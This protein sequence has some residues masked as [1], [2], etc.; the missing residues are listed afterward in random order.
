MRSHESTF[1]RWNFWKKDF[2]SAAYQ[3]IE[4]T[5]SLMI[6]QSSTAAAGHTDIME[7]DRER[8]VYGVGLSWERAV[9]FTAQWQRSK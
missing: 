2:Q 5:P 3:P 1:N 7:R 8:E 6:D 9:L 4:D